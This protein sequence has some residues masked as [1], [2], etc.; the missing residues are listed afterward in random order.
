MLQLHQ[1]G[2]SFGLP[3]ASPFCMKVEA[4]LRVY[5]IPYET[6][7]VVNPAAGPYG[8]APWIV[9]GDAAIPDSRLIFDYLR[10]KYGDRLGAG[11]GERQ[12]GEHRAVQRLLEESLYFTLMVERWLRPENSAATTQA[13]FAALPPLARGI[14]FRLARRGMARA[15]HGQGIA[16]L[17]AAEIDRL[18]AED[19]NALAQLL[20]EQPYFGGAQLREIDLVAIAFLANVLRPPLH[21]A[22][23][24]RAQT[25]SNLVAYTDRVMHEVFPD[26]CS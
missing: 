24:R 10:D 19:I 21:S 6:V 8:K 7:L 26:F 5:D 20:G 1:F 16:R 18:G 14:V 11:L 15:L 2:R 12:R 9:D 25:K 4:L 22:L 13:L 3:N 17:T 23:R